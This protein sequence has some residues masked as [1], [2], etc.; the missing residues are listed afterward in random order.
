MTRVEKIKRIRTYRTHLYMRLKKEVPGILENPD[1]ASAEEVSI[2]NEL[3]ADEAS[4]DTRNNA[5]FVKNF[6]F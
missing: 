6:S 4:R 3:I 5:T 2:Y 1:N